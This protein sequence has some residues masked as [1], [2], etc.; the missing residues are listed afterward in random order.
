MPGKQAWEAL[1]RLAAPS[2]STAPCLDHSA[3]GPRGQRKAGAM[4]NGF[5]RKERAFTLR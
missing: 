4:V 5:E 1:L 3:P 2:A